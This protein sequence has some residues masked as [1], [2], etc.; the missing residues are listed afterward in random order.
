[1][2]TRSQRSALFA[3]A[4]VAGAAC[5]AAV[6]P[7][8]GTKPGGRSEDAAA[9][10]SEHDGPTLMIG[11]P[12]GGALDV[13]AATDGVPI[14]AERS[15]TAQ[16]VP[17]DLFFVVDGSSSMGSMIGAR[18]KWQMARDALLAFARDP[19]SAGLGLGLQMFPQPG[20][21]SPCTSGRDCDSGG[22]PATCRAQRLCEG[23]PDEN[24]ALL[25]CEERP[26][27]GGAR[28]L[29][30]GR[31][32]QSGLDC[33]AIDAPCP[34]M[35]GDV[36]KALGMACG[37]TSGDQ[38]LAAAAYEIPAAP[39]TDLPLPGARLV[40]RALEARSP[41][42]PTPLRN[43]VLGSLTYLERHLAAHP[44][45]HGV[46]IIATDGEP[47]CG[48]GNEPIGPLV[49]RLTMARQGGVS[50]YVV[51]ILA[52]DPLGM[53]NINALATAGG[54]GAPF[55]IAMANDFQ[56]RFLSSLNE[57][58]GAALPCE[59]TIPPPK[60]GAIDYGKVNLRLVHGAA[61][62]DVLYTGGVD[63]CGKG[64]WYYDADPAM[65]APSRVIA[66]PS[67]CQSWKADG[68]A[69]VE[70]RFGCATRIVE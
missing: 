13:P 41:D 64:G 15:E 51:G 63:H 32:S 56:E 67:T 19:R 6:D 50:T 70:L 47:A 55:L 30:G 26:C 65:K 21:G 9:P 31:C 58:R 69:T 37:T 11:V 68:K 57:I 4:L 5:S 46:L 62:E 61:T 39:I 38:C 59:F 18:T 8:S 22:N 24:G 12:D 16:L 3:S 36:C 52:G 23:D 48:M 10:G 35:T 42:G 34:G 53:A 60:T 27:A 66:C 44:G 40:A 20:G 28:C 2:L 29:P 1:M 17:V 45:R 25:H 33:T 43:G 49:D 54:A 7:A 14:C